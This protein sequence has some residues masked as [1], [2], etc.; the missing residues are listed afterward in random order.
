MINSMTGY[1]RAELPVN[2]AEGSSGYLVEIRSVNH[3][4]LDLSVKCPRE[5][6]PLEA[7]VRR[8]AGEKISRGKVDIFI[9]PQKGAEGK[10]SRFSLNMEQG[11]EVLAELNRMR[12]ELAIPGEVDLAAVLEFKTILC[13][14]ETSAINIEE[15]G[16]AVELA[17]R[18]A[19]ENLAAMRAAE[20]STLENDLR[21]RIG[22]IEAILQR[23]RPLTGEVVA[24]YRKRLA[25]RIEKLLENIQ[26]DST[27][28]EEE[29]AY[30]ADR[31]DIT[32]EIVRAE[33]HIG[34][35]RKTISD[36]GV[37]GKKLDFILQEIS[38]EINTIG[39]KANDARIASEVIAAKS[40][41]EKVREQVQNIE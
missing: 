41:L 36:G 40:E 2:T 9:S 11:R 23:I 12:E 33:S 39:S 6:I 16:G 25:Q 4:Y 21:E 30:F 24:D 13:T 26:P 7:A 28:L 19:V 38:R 17:V 5:F 15:A 27:K 22:N 31:C 1:G 37:A 20:G 32:E 35:F 29:V 10:A 3:R 14:E 18:K 8:I 34:Q